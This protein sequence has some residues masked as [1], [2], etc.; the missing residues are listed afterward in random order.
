MPIAAEPP[1]I[2]VS[3]GFF[4]QDRQTAHRYLSPHDNWDLL[5]E[6][7]K[8]RGPLAECVIV[9]GRPTNMPCRQTTLGKQ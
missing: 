5:L 9:D 2:Y 3:V 7:E 6:H 8:E 4:H 1:T